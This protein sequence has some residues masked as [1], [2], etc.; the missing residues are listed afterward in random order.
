MD[1]LCI[2]LR[3]IKHMKKQLDHLRFCF[4]ISLRVLKHFEAKKNLRNPNDF[5]K[6]LKISLPKLGAPRPTVRL[7]LDLDS[8]G[9][10][11]GNG[12]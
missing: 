10:L 1:M 6:A 5:C 7:A 4:R 2:F 3:G 12:Q 9:S 11:E 8:E